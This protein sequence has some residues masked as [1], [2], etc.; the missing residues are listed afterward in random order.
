MASKAPAPPRAFAT[1][2]PQSRRSLL[3]VPFRA[4]RPSLLERP[5]TVLPGVGPAL[6]AGAARLGIV[7]LGDV[8]GHL[9]FDHRD[10]ER[11]RQVAELALGEEATVS[12]AVCS[13][14]VRPTR[15]RRLTI[16]ECK[17]ADDSGPMKAV[18]FN[19]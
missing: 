10:Y 3:S 6:A 18:W 8:L 4:P 2:A 16:L 12:G 13:A 9:P 17:V 5:V 15:R 1:A 11:R 14:H 7:T 19:Q